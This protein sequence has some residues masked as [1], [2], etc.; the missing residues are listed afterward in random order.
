ML[1]IQLIK[2]SIADRHHVKADAVGVKSFTCSLKS[3]SKG[4][5]FTAT[6]TSDRMDRDD[7]VLIPSG[8][9]PTEFMTGKRTIFWNHD[10]SLPIGAAKTLKQFDNRWESEAFIAENT[11]K[12]TD[13]FPDYVWSLLEQD[14]LGGVSVG[15]VPVET[16][17]PTQKDYE[18]YGDRLRNVVSKWKLLEWSIAPLQA[19][20]DGVVTAVQKGL[21]KLDHAKRVF[22]NL[23]IPEAQKLIARVVIAKEMSLSEMIARGL[24]KADGMLY[25][26]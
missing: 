15:F 23:I 19:N 6:I 13:F 22:P 25:D 18:R 10:Y 17:R 12:M 8:M 24:R 26:N 4:R 3:A 21:V 7:E 5:S 2:Q 16:R 1:D 14:I 20:I 11:Q 9:I